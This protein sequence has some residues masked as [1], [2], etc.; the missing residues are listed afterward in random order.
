MTSKTPRRI[1]EVI[2][3]ETEQNRFDRSNKTYHYYV[4]NSIKTAI[5]PEDL[6]V[7]QS[8]GGYLTLARVKAVLAESERAKLCTRK[9]IAVVDIS[10]HLREQ[11]TIA[12]KAELLRTLGEMDKKRKEDL[13]LAE[14][15]AAMPEAGP[16]VEELRALNDAE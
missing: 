1:V 12:R 5:K 10:H 3:V 4:P 15:A 9:V 2:Y 8:Q 13:R 16:L 11:E 14:L 7:V 6:V